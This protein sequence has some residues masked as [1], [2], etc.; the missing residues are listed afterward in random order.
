MRK[1]K[2]NEEQISYAATQQ[3]TGTPVGEITRKLGISEQT[4]CC[5][6]FFSLQDGGRAPK[7]PAVLSF[8]PASQLGRQERVFYTLCF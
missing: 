3:E 5:G 8:A 7:K 1:S 2:F 4:F 6:P